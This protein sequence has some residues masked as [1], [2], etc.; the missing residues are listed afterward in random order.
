MSTLSYDGVKTAVP[1]SLNNARIDLNTGVLAQGAFNQI[2]APMAGALNLDNYDYFFIATGMAIDLGPLAFPYTF[3][4]VLNVRLNGVLQTNFVCLHTYSLQ[5][6]VILGTPTIGG[7][8][9]AIS[10][11]AGNLVTVQLDGIWAMNFAGNGELSA[12]LNFYRKS[13]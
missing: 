10:G 6:G 9:I 4:T 12:T 2:F 5:T 13:A 3:T 8:L 11:I 1:A 7:E